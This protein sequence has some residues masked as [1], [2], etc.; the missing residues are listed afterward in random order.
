MEIKDEPLILL[1]CSPDSYCREGPDSCLGE[2]PDPDLG[3][4]T[5]PGWGEGPDP[6]SS[7]SSGGARTSNHAVEN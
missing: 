5:D 7:C 6:G 1:T 3:P 2:G 4:E